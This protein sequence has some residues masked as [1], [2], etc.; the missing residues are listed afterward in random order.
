MTFSLLWDTKGEFL[1]KVL[2][3]LFSAEDETGA[4]RF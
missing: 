2:A 1:F 3:T 4:I